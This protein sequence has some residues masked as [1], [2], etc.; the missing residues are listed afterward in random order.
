[1]L[2]SLRRRYKKAKKWA[3]A[4]AEQWVIECTHCGHAAPAL[5]RGVVR[6]GASSK[7]KRVLAH[8]TN[9]KSTHWAR[10]YKDA[11]LATELRLAETQQKLDDLDDASPASPATA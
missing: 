8:C 3:K 5:E 4:S 10:L 7:G 1:M 11:I 9:C 2:R 6:V